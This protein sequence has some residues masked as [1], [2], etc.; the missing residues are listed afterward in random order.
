MSFTF[1][2][3]RITR[4]RIRYVRFY[5]CLFQVKCSLQLRNNGGVATMLSKL[6]VVLD[7]EQVEISIVKFLL[8]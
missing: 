7:P 2:S 1:G 3:D 8:V 5:F 6:S 4:C